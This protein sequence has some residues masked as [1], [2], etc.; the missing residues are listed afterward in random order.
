MNL[1]FASQ[2]IAEGMG[3]EDGDHSEDYYGVVGE[4]VVVNINANIDIVISAGTIVRECERTNAKFSDPEFDIESD[5]SACADNCLFGIVRACDDG[6]DD[7]DDGDGGRPLKP[8]SVH[9]VPWI[10]ERPQFTVNDF[11]SDLIQGASRNCW[12]LAALATINCRKDLMERICVARDEECGVYGFVFYRDGEWISTVVDDNL[13][14]TQEDFDQ[15][16]YDAAGK[17]AKLYKKQKQSGSDALFFAKCGD[18]NETWLPLLEKAFA[19]IHGDYGALDGGWAGTAVEDLTGGVTTVLAG[20]RVLRKERL[21]REMG[22]NHRNGLILG[23]DYSVLEATEVEDELGNEISLVKI[24]NPWGERCASGHGEWN[25]PWSDGSEEWTPFM[26]EKLRHKFS[27]NGTFWMSFHDM[28]DNF[29]WIY[30]TRLFDEGWITVQRWMSVNLD[31]RYFQGLEGQYEFTLHFT[32]RSLG[33]SA[34][35]C[36]VQPAPQWN[37]RSVN[38]EITLKP[39]KYE[40][41]PNIVA[42]RDEQDMS[43]E[44]MIRLTTLTNPSK[45]RQVGKQ[46]DRAHA[47]AEITDNEMPHDRAE[48]GPERKSGSPE[49]RPK[50]VADTS[51]SKTEAESQSSSANS[52]SDCDSS[53]QPWNAVCI[54]GLRVYTQ[55]A[56]IRISLEDGEWQH[57]HE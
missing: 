2:S 19:K 51:G 23:H 11:S 24:R 15:E 34:V 56:C 33:D 18:A 26:M 46:Y 13:Y 3:T 32:L 41:I 57:S 14:L 9:R 38:C 27:D 10:F 40:V 4:G 52:D 36:Q 28:L 20:D 37:T 25:G 6:D 21:W 8:G 31:D 53:Q 1:D 44:R 48:D 54:V 50:P 49:S 16:I 5:F 47:K 35:I 12:W 29:R 45:L 30:R 55:Q 43:V 39:G 17:K 42:E 22:D 7:D